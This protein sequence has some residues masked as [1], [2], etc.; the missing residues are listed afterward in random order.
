MT[1][2]DGGNGRRVV[3]ERAA[4][5]R[6]TIAE[7]VELEHEREADLAAEDRREEE[8][9]ARRAPP[10]PEIPT[11]VVSVK[12]FAPERVSEFRARWPRVQE[13]FVEVPRRSLEQAGANVQDVVR[14]LGASFARE[15]SDLERRVAAG[16]NVS[17]EDLRIAL[18]RYKSFFDR[19]LTL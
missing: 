19:L 11:G 6:A 8:T 12:P 18:R 15:R 3:D 4:E 16:D 17:T 1:E 2:R 5:E 9:A 7:R 10:I 13:L 14:E